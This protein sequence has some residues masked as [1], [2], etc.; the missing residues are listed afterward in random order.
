[1]SEDNKRTIAEIMS[2]ELVTVTE[3]QRLS[4]V[5]HLMAEHKIHHVPV[6]KGRACIG[7]ISSTDLMRVNWGDQYSQTEAVTDALLDT[8]S[9]RDAMQEDIKTIHR[10]TTVVEAA[11]LFADGMYHSL[12]VVDDDDRLVG[13]LTT[14]DLL[15]YLLRFAPS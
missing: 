12:P 6:I 11:R 7:L 4:V 9:I 3:E 13:M 14:T 10:D 15:R 2:V 5:R 1:M 8:V